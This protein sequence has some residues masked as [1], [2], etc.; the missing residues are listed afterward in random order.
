MAAAVGGRGEDLRSRGWCCCARAFWCVFCCAEASAAVPERV[1]SME[2][3]YADGGGDMVIE[4]ELV[5]GR[6]EPRP[7]LE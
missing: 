4:R 7:G 1:L 2:F 3:L 5:R 6:E